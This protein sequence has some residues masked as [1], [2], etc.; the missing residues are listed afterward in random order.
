LKESAT[1][2]DFSVV[3][4]AGARIYNKCTVKKA[5]CK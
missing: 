4:E 1:T 5:F 3:Q 2:E